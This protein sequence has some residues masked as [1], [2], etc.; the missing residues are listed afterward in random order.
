MAAL[1][2]GI[3]VGAVDT[4]VRRV[5]GRIVA[6]EAGLLSPVEMQRLADAAVPVDRA[7][8]WTHAV[9]DVGATLCRPRSPDCAA[10]PARP[11]CRYAGDARGAGD[12]ADRP[13]E[14]LPESVPLHSRPPR[15]GSAVASWTVSV[16][17]R[18]G[19]WV[20]F[21]VSIGAHDAETVQRAVTALAM[22]GLVERDVGQ[23]FVVRARLPLA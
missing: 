21:D 14:V 2:F 18:D 3:P 9:M 10:C 19:E 23:S 20:V 17:A 13:P 8:D 11:W 5:L 16:S 12:A 15:A 1:A 6:G 7:A 4:N 22:E